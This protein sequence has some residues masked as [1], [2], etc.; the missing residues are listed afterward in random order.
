VSPLRTIL[1]LLRG[2]SAA[3]AV[4]NVAMTNGL[5]LCLNVM[6]GVLTARL[7]GPEGR[8]ELAALL[9]WPQFLAQA[10]AFALPSAVIYHT[11]KDPSQRA[12]IAGRGLLLSLAGGALAAVV[13][14]VAMPWLLRNADAEL[15]RRA[16]WMMVFA[17]MGTFSML[18]TALVQ[19]QERFHFYNFIRYSPL[20]LTVS[21]L[22]L[23]QAT[24]TLTPLT[25][26]LA[27][28]LPGIPVYAVMIVSVVRT[29][30]PTLRGTGYARRLISYGA[31]AYGGE[32]AGTLLSYLDKLVLVNLLSLSA[33]G[34]YI[35]IF[36]LSRVIVTLGSS[37]A[38]V[39]FPRTAG[40]AADDVFRST[41]RA[42]DVAT[43]LLLLCALG[44]TALGGIALRMLYG[45]AFGGG[46]GALIMLSFEAMLFSI[47]YVLVQPFL[48]LDRPGIVTFVQLAF[49]GVLALM[50]WLLV[51][52]LGV[53]GAALA[54]LLTTAVRV[55]ATHRAFRLFG[56][57]R[58]PRILP[59]LRG[60]VAW[61]RRLREAS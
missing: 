16:R 41:E 51:P 50:M 19:L 26:A 2:S 10:F 58:P 39:L 24:A 38:P 23:L 14:V 40:R 42:L 11:R 46:H 12:E 17:P 22:L 59:D 45:A 49:V 31:R 34:T 48:A 36:N 37:I 44:S 56:G 3:S 27:Y 1:R 9:L 30:R 20:I 43:P 8:G 57:I 18:L 32:A 5:V 35:V 29:L 53:N 21:G 4:A 52:P 13:G 54:L 28:Y 6:T 7:L 60:A 47:A 61:F 55:L 15:V 33:Y 25:G